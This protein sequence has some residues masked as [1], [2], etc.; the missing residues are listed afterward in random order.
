MVCINGPTLTWIYLIFSFSKHISILVIC[1]WASE[2]SDFKFYPQTENTH[3]SGFQRAMVSQDSFFD[4]ES[5]E[6][7]CAKFYCRQ[8]KNC[9]FVQLEK[10]KITSRFH[11][12]P[13]H[14]MKFSLIHCCVLLKTSSL[15]DSF[16]WNSFV[17]LWEYHEI[18][19]SMLWWTSIE[20]FP[21]S[22]P[23]QPRFQ[24]NIK[25]RSSTKFLTFRNSTYENWLLGCWA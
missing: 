2:Q 5:C 14:E 7:A 9:F 16:F 11:K 12:Q 13:V 3:Y 24:I 10:K 4:A 21:W 19:S 17:M 1:T 22:C 23:S 6:A 25:D 15:V 18:S 8:A 20:K